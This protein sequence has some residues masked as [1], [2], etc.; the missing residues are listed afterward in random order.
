MIPL[1]DTITRAEV[2]ELE[3]AVIRTFQPP[4]N[5]QHTEAA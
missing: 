5:A 2:V 4:G 1:D 3:R